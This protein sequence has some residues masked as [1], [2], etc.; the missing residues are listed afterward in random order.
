MV[1]QRLPFCGIF[2]ATLSDAHCKRRKTESPTFEGGG[3]PSRTLL[4]SP[5]DL[6]HAFPETVTYHQPECILRRK[7]ESTAFSGAQQTAKYRSI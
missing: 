1:R 2:I 6:E 4:R 7:R 5:S 3:V